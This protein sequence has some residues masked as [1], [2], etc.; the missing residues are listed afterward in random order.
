MTAV[1]LPR[2]AKLRAPVFLMACALLLAG[3]A[4]RAAEASDPASPPTI[5]VLDLDL[6][7]TSGEV[8]DQRED[9]ARRLAAMATRLRTDFEAQ[10]IYRV[11]DTPELRARIAETGRSQYLSRC[12]GCEL[13]LARGVDADRVLTGVVYKV[14]SLVLS[15]TVTIKDAATGEPLIHKALDFRGDNDAAWDR[16]TRYFLRYLAAVPPARR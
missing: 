13:V 12:N 6:I 15:L 16:A 5:A 14:S 3:G 11:I 7:D 9:H 8:T 4:T 2:L 1:R 10:G